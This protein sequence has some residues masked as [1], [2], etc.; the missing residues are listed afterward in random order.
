MKTGTPFSGGTVAVPSRRPWFSRPRARLATPGSPG[1]GTSD[2][3][4]CCM[5]LRPSLPRVEAIVGSF[6]RPPP[7]FQPNPN[8]CLPG[9]KKKPSSVVRPG[10]HHP[11]PLVEV[12]KALRLP[13]PNHPTPS[14]D[15][16][17]ASFSSCRAS[18]EPNSSRHTRG[19][20]RREE[21]T[22]GSSGGTTRGG[23]NSTGARHGA[24]SNRMSWKMVVSSSWAP[25]FGRHQ[26]IWKLSIFLDCQRS[27]RNWS[28]TSSKRS[29]AANMFVG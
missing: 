4:D 26:L 18:G 19:L 25:T 10:S 15:P 24:P 13:R 21:R 9:V 6:S 2:E 11:Q 17:P 8:S 22:G 20:P 29:N 14:S 27:E 5:M 7:K 12:P 23:R 1:V 3:S 28:G 16:K